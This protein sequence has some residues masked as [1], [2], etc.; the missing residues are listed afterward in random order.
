M[1]P[2]DERERP[3]GA[4]P[5]GSGARSASGTTNGAAARP[6]HC[7]HARAW[8]ARPGSSRTSIMIRAVAASRKGT[9][10]VAHPCRPAACSSSG[11]AAR[12]CRAAMSM[13][14]ASGAASYQ[15]SKYRSS[16]SSSRASSSGPR[17]TSQ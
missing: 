4:L 6:C 9:R 15:P 12:P 5:R 7:N 2:H 10:G 1:L 17:I 3:L 16:A 8:S 14:G 11:S 13:S